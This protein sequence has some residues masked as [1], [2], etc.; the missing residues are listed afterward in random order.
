MNSNPYPFHADLV[1]EQSLRKRQ[2]NLVLVTLMAFILTATG[3]AAGIGVKRNWF[4]T[5]NHNVSSNAI[6][7]QQQEQIESELVTV[8]RFGFMPLA[9]K[10]PAK[11]FV[12]TIVNRTADPELKLTLNRSVGNRP[13]DK[14]I[15]VNLKRGRG[16]WYAHFSLPPGDYELSEASHPEWKCQITLTPR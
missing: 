3:V 4:T 15:D 9:I 6:A 1:P 13:T 10:R 5:T 16:S 14:I 7:V 2:D 11:D 8:N 12:M